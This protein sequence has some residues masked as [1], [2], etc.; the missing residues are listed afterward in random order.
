MLAFGKNGQT[1]EVKTNIFYI[2]LVQ[3]TYLEVLNTLTFAAD[4]DEKMLW[5]NSKNTVTLKNN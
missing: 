5:R 2:L 1:D 3:T 4:G